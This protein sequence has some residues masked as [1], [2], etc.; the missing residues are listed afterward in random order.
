MNEHR[1]N[2]QEFIDRTAKLSRTELHNL[3]PSEA[4]ALYRVLPKVS[5]VLDLGCGN[6]AMASISNKISEKTNYTGVDH[7]KNLMESAKT[8]FPFANF[9]YSD[10]LEYLQKCK[11]YECIMSWSVIKSFSNWREIIKEI[12]NKSSKKVIFDLRVANVDKEIFDENICWAEYGNIKGAHILTNYSELKN[13]IKSLSCSI[14]KAE[15]VAYK[16]DYGK[17]V[18]FNIKKP[19]F[20]LVCC[21]LDIKKSEDNNAN[22]IEF[23]EQIP[24]QLNR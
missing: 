14:G 10:L 19:D 21:V 18:H 13:T 8:L 6:G 2:T 9:Y 1:W 15:L 3:Y 24:S 17:N 11:M 4:W 12:V 23:Y 20:F 7:Q 5:N 22:D 16:S